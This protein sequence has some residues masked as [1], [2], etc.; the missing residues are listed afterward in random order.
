MP[1]FEGPVTRREILKKGVI[2]AVGLT[3]IPAVVAACSTSS[4]TTAPTAAA[5]T[6]PV[7]TP[8]PTKPDYTGRT[9]TLWHYESATGAMGQS[10]AAAVDTFLATHPGAKVDFQSKA[11]E[12]IQQNASQVLNSSSAPDV[13]EYNKG[14]ATAGL[15]S[16][17]G[18]LTDLTSVAT[19]RGWDK[20][21]TP[22]LQTTCMYS[23]KGIMGS[24]KWF[25][26]TTYGEYVFV[27]YNKDMFTK[28]NVSVP[29]T[30]SSR[31]ES[32][33]LRLLAPSTRPSRSST[34]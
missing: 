28:Y 20:I 11:F 13:M 27:Y 26:V 6:G 33:R 34:S 30:P 21:L 25:G 22:S 16:T 15:L 18:L 9:L 12:Q 14:N 19:A 10:W 31:P 29:T 24:G 23:D 3:A 1:D 32:R 5:S 17:Q 8:A 4:A 2:G 7:I